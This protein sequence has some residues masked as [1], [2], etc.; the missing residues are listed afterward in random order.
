MLTLLAIFDLNPVGFSQNLYVAITTQCTPRL[1]LV[2]A[3][4]KCELLFTVNMNCN[5]CWKLKSK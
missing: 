3:G 2:A 1:R 4:Y 5:G